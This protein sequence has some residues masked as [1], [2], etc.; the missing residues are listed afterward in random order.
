MYVL[1]TEEKGSDVN[2]GTHLIMDAYENKFD[3]AIVVSNDS[4]LAEPIK[5]VNNMPGLKVRLLNPYLRTNFK[6]QE[7]VNKDMKYIRASA[8][9][10]S[11]FPDNL[12]DVNGN[13]HKPDTWVL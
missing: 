12:E 10:D 5:I 6:L 1:K 3:V 4:D 13:F 11:Q 2:L 7:A 8:L 9:R